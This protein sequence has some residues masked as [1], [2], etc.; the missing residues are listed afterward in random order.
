MKSEVKIDGQKILI[1][2]P[3]LAKDEPPPPPPEPTEIELLDR[4][5]RPLAGQRFVIELRDGTQ[6]I[7]VTDE[8]GMSTLDLPEDGT[9]RFPEL[10]DVEAR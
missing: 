5:G 10:A 4:Q 9:L 1:N 6:R 8:R 2:S 7:G 3:E